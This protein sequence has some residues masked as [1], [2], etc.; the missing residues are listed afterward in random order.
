[1]ANIL[2]IFW[3]EL[4]LLLRDAGIIIFVF[5][6]P[7]FYPLLYAY[8]YTNE[9]VRNVPCAVVDESSSS[10]SRDFIRK[11]DATPNVD[12]VAVCHN[13]DEALRLLRSRDAFGVLHFPETMS[14]DIARGR[15]THL[16]YY[17]DMSSMMYY[18][19]MLAGINNVSLDM[20]RDIRIERYLGG[21]TERQEAVMKMPVEYD[22]TPLFNP[23]GGFACFLIPPVLMLII[24]QTMLLGMGMQ[25]GNVR[26]KYGCAIPRRHYRASHFVAGKALVF[27]VIYLLVAV[28]MF[29]CV[30][31]LFHLMHLGDYWTFLVF[32]TPYI[33][34]CVFFSM[35]VSFLIYR[36]E[37]CILLFMFLSVPFLFISG[38]SWPSVAIPD[39]WR[40]VAHAIPSTFG[41]PG[42]VRIAS[43]GASLS[44]VMPEFVALWI[45]VFVYA[46]LT[47]FLYHRDLKR[48]SHGGCYKSALKE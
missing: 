20:G 47:L 11:L 40:V 2:I 8:V 6:A 12:V 37:D 14:D 13:M 44:D 17:S 41:M 4:R 32:V 16:G 22:Y 28:Y 48:M 42:Y 1:M 34:S 21:S 27:F 5:L 36:R 19:T 15:Q 46:L 43:M 31:R 18:K 30:N 24:Q 3:N 35:S 7:L 33:L 38:I 25:M 39:L 45:Q 10:L 26:E 29:T 23:Q 9:V